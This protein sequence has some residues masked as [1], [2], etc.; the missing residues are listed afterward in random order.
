MFVCVLRLWKPKEA[1]S[2]HCENTHR[3]LE[4]S[5]TT[6]D[7]ETEMYKEIALYKVISYTQIITTHK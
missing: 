7:K 3:Q 5:F 4:D 2:Q 1:D 6:G